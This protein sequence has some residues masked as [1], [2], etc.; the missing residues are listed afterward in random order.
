APQTARTSSV[1]GRSV[2]ERARGAG[3]AAVNAPPEGD[4]AAAPTRSVS[5]SP[6][7][8]LSAGPSLGARRP[9]TTRIAM[10]TTSATTA[11]PQT[12]P[13]PSGASS[14]PIPISAQA[15]A[16]QSASASVASSVAVPA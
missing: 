9:S 13:V 15:T 5:R 12:A 1:A 6:A 4:A 2:Q 16:Y 11:T 14:D 7:T 8:R 3:S 10:V